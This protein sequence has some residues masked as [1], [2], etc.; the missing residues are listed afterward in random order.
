[1]QKPARAARRNMLKGLG[2]IQRKY[3]GNRRAKR[4]G[5][6]QGSEE[7]YKVNTNGNRA[8]DARRELPWCVVKYKGDTMN[9]R[10]KNRRAERAGGFCRVLGKIQKI[11]RSYMAK[12]CARSAPIFS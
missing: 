1:M 6:F 2:K 12:T 4:A 10:S 9:K 8:R 3:K 7:N 5:K 11:Q